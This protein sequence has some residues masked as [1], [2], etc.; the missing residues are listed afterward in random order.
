MPRGAAKEASNAYNTASSN[1][2]SLYGT[3]VPQAEALTKSTGYDPAT[4]GAITNAGMG[5]VNAAFTGAGNQIARNTARTKNQASDASQQDVLAQQRGIAGGKEA[6]DIQI[7]NADFAQ[8]QRTQGLNLLAGMYGQNL[9]QEVPAINAQTN[10]SPGWA[11]SLSGIM[12][13]AGS[14]I[15]GIKK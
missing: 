15:S 3:L 7:Q 12:S 13:G 6:G 2:G 4:L 11:Q 9:G 14:L 1:A 8:Q 10:A 5:G